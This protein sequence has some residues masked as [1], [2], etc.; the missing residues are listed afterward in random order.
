MGPLPFCLTLFHYCQVLSSDLCVSYLDDVAIEGPCADGLQDLSVV[1]EVED[2]GL[3]LDV[4]K[5]EIITQDHTT[6]DT[7]LTSLP[8]A[9]NVDPTYATFLGCPLGDGRC[10]S[11]AIGEKA[12]VLKRVG[13]RFVAL[14][15]HDA[16]ILL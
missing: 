3:N 11:K 7:I 4:S 9:H 14:L 6:F 1:K 2:I 15:A 10:I 13:E 5:C 16:F 8:D 12:A